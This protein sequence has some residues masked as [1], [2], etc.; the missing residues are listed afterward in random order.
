MDPETEKLVDWNGKT[1]LPIDPKSF[2]LIEQ[3][4]IDYINHKKRCFIVDGYAGWDSNHRV[5][6]RAYC[7]RTYHALFMRNMLIRPT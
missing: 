3:F 4:A 1:N 6:V 5:K 2:E 7:T